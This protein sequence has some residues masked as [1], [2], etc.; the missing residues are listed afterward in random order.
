MQSATAFHAIHDA[1]SF[2]RNAYD[3][4]ASYRAALIRLD[5][6]LDANDARQG[7]AAA[8]DRAIRRRRGAR[9]RTSTC[10]RPTG[11]PW[12]QALDLR[13]DPGE[14]AGD[15]RTVGQRQDHAAARASRDCGRTRRAGC[16]CPVDER[17]A[18]FVSQLP[19]LPLGDLRAVASYPRPPTATSTTTPIQQALLKVALPHLVIRINEV[20]DWA[21]VLSVGEQQRIAF[22]RILLD[23]GRRRCSSTSR[24]RRWTRAWN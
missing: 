14:S 12:S 2:F 1:L 11:D 23:A 8:D 3:A 24:R 5:G 13:L 10:A 6:L 22:A 20:K 21:K 15:H 16:G 7:V 17:E 19:Y 18:M 4:F 9:S